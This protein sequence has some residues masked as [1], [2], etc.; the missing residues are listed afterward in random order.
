MFVIKVEQLTTGTFGIFWLPYLCFLLKLID[1]APF[2]KTWKSEQAVQLFWAIFLFLKLLKQGHYETIPAEQKTEQ[3]T[4]TA[5]QQ[6]KR[7]TACETASAVCMFL[8]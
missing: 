5:Q 7:E 2:D 8:V 1:C 3:K 4:G 6:L